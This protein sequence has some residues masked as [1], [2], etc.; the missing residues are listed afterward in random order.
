MRTGIIGLQPLQTLGIRWVC[1]SLGWEDC[2]VYGS[3]AELLD[4]RHPPEIIIASA[5]AVA[6]AP[7]FFMPRRQKLVILA[8]AAPGADVPTQTL[9]TTMGEEEMAGV[10]D[11]LAARL[12]T[13]ESH[14]ELSAREAEVLREVAAGKTNKEIADT[15]CIS[16][17]TV[18]THRKNITSKL[19]IRSASGLSVY[20]LMNGIAPQAHHPEG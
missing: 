8:D 19:G 9:L 7:Q 3:V 13:P 12:R 6:L 16:I 14:E 1:A 20:A 18:I 5:D 17:N 10:L 4:S 11:S 2:D 15:L